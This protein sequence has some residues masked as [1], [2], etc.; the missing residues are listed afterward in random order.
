MH[1]RC[2]C[3]SVGVRTCKYNGD[4]P[5][6]ATAGKQAEGRERNP[7]ADEGLPACIVMEKGECLT[8]YLNSSKASKML[9]DQQFGLRVYSTALLIA[10]ID[11][12]FLLLPHS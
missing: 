8:E 11:Y 6:P 10:L 3:K 12:C 2:V 5:E 1:N 7:T 4:R 9:E